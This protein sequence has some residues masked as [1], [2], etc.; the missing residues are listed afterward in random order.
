MWHLDVLVLNKQSRE[1]DPLKSNG[2][3]E[4]GI[5]FTLLWY[6]SVGPPLELGIQC[7]HFSSPFPVHFHWSVN[8]NPILCILFISLI[9]FL[10][11]CLD[12]VIFMLYKFTT[13][14]YKNSFFILFFLRQFYY[15]S[16]AIILVFAGHKISALSSLTE[17]TNR[18]FQH[19]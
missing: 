12:I 11:F 2:I 15:I 19:K 4:D 5:Y 9:P 3:L 18:S 13:G 1:V 16:L 10:F 8:L 7:Y 17:T 14:T 6:L